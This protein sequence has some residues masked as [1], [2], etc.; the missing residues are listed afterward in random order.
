VPSKRYQ[1][2]APIR[3]ANLQRLHAAVAHI[4][5]RYPGARRAT[6]SAGRETDLA[7]DHSEHHHL[8][9]A[10]IERIA[11]DLRQQGFSVTVSSIH[12]NAWLGSHDKAQGAHWIVE[13]LWGRRLADERERWVTVGDSTNDEGLFRELPLSVGVA[14]IARFWPQMRDRPVYV[15]PAARGDGFAELVEAILAP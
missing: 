11:S 12:I 9:A 6:D 14:N 15:T 10:T 4:E 7:I 3:S 2:D 1:Q 8:D 5:A 13:Q